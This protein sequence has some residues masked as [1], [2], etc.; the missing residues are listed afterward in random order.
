M[1]KGGIDNRQRKLKYWERNMS[2]PTVK[3]KFSLI[4]ENH[5]EHDT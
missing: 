3:L 5:L 1:E 4:R 2:V